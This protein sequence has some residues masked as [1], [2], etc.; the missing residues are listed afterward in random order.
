MNYRLFPNIYVIF[1]VAPSGYY[2]MMFFVIKA[3]KWKTS[4]QRPLKHKPSSYGLLQSNFIFF[5]KLKLNCTVG[6]DHIWQKEKVFENICI[7]VFL[8]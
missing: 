7:N 1:S 5:N 4:F 3:R 6:L 2:A 8:S